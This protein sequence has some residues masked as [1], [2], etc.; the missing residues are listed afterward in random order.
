MNLFS[1]QRDLY[2]TEI[3]DY[4]W[5]ILRSNDRI[6]ELELKLRAVNDETMR[7]CETVMG[8]EQRIITLEENA[9]MNKL[10]IARLEKD[11]SSGN[12]KLK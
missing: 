6:S 12:F 10:E 11:L 8:K 7:S 3:S 9:K 5:S 1:K 4:K 2:E